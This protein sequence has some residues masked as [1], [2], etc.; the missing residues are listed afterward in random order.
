MSFENRELSP[1]GYAVP[2]QAIDITQDSSV[3]FWTQ[4]LACSELELRVAVADVGDVAS[5]VGTRLGR[6]M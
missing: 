2:S 4:K 3:N 5:D 1:A 6:V